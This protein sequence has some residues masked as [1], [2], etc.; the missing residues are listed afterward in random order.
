[1][2]DVVS[3]YNVK[4]L[5]KGVEITA[6]VEFEP[7]NGRYS[8]SWSESEI[9]ASGF[10]GAYPGYEVVMEASVSDNPHAFVACVN[11]LYRVKGFSKYPEEEEVIG[12][13]KIKVRSLRFRKSL[14]NLDDDELNDKRD[15][16]VPFLLQE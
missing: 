7:R 2:N 11:G 9:A 13:G 5:R 10:A 12:L 3:K 4:N 15:R 16:K 1:M 6:D 8:S 14:I